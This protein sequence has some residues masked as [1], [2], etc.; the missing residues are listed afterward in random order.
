MLENIT[1]QK[2]MRATQLAKYL[3]VGVS[4][5]WLYNKQGKIQSIKM[6]ERVTVFDVEAVENALLGGSL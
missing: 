2:Y 3:G 5:V 4:T 1:K 6:S